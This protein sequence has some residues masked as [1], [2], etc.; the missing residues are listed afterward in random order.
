MNKILNIANTNLGA[1]VIGSLI[2]AALLGISY[3]AVWTKVK[4]FFSMFYDII[5]NILNYDIKAW[6]VIL[7]C[8]FVV[9]MWF[10][11]DK[12]LREK[13]R[14]KRNIEAGKTTG[15]IFLLSNDETLILST[16]KDA[17]R[18][19]YYKKDFFEH[20]DVRHFGK[21]KV[22]KLISDLMRYGLLTI[23]ANAIHGNFYLLT[24]RGEEYT[25]KHFAK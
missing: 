19:R 4:T 11:Y 25:L 12:K 6:I 1:T 24:K 3:S 23:G 16:L 8:F 21:D 22:N 20:K 2:V 14:Y 18:E 17:D 13:N 5:V 7:L 9:L 10:V 15:G